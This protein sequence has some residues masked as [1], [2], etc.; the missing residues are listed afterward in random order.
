MF[1]KRNVSN[2]RANAATKRV[3]KAESDESEDNSDVE[4]KTEKTIDEDETRKRSSSSE[5]ETVVVRKKTKNSSN[6]PMIQKSSS[7]KLNSKVD[8]C[9]NGEDSNVAGPSVRKERLKPLVDFTFKSSRSGVVSGPEDQ[10][11]TATVQVDTE[12]DRDHRAVMERKHEAQETGDA[13]SIIYTGKDNYTIFNKPKEKPTGVK[14]ALTGPVRAPAFLRATT[15][16]DY[17]PDLCKD[18][19]E[20]GFCGFGDSCKFLH[21]RTDYKFGWQLENE[22]TE[23]QKRGRTKESEDPSQYEIDSSDEDDLPFKCL[24]CRESFDK[25]VVTKCK[26]YFCEKCALAQCK[27][28]MRCFICGVD[29]KGMFNPAKEIIAKMNKSKAEEQ[30]RSTRDSD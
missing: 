2:A 17:A 16:W 12:I 26:H 4:K 23:Q 11:A 18:Y 7:C 28:S 13:S 3:A 8:G 21:D 29:T 30:S 5:D 9:D 10:G 1:K 27:K 15:R 25:P 24:I 6:N 20:T 14:A 22:H 19:K